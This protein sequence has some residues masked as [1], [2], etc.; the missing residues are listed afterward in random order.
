MGE[1]LDYNREDNLFA[2]FTVLFYIIYIMGTKFW[3]A[4]SSQRME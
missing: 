4:N 3:N 1:S 2:D